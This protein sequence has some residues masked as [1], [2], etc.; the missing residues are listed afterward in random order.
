[1]LFAGPKKILYNTSVRGTKTICTQ[2]A[3]DGKRNTIA[4]AFIAA[5]G[6]IWQTR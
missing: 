4:G 2:A 5:S 1:M 3:S 6:K